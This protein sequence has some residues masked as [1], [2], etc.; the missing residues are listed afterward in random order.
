MRQS[1]KAV[2]V[3]AGTE[4]SLAF[5]NVAEMTSQ[6]ERQA[7][8]VVTEVE[9]EGNGDAGRGVAIKLSQKEVMKEE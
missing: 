5:V 4:S 2:S 1:S 8:S 6:L 9:V 7:A 3:Y